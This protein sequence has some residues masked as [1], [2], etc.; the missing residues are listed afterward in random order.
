MRC[1]AALARSRTLGCARSR[2]RGRLRLDRPGPRDSR[3][4]TTGFARLEPRNVRRMSESGSLVGRDLL[5]VADL[6]TDEVGLVFATA[7]RLKAEYREYRRHLEPPLV[8]PDAGDAVPEAEPADAGDVRCGHD[9]ARRQRDLPDQRHRAGRPRERPGRR[10][11]PRALR[12]RDRGP[13]GPARG[14]RGARLAGRASRSS[15]A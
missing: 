10:P 8:G 3:Y 14:R 5:S 1:S 9:P 2:A 15:T 11:Q 4:P 13:D 12:R 7:T 6:S